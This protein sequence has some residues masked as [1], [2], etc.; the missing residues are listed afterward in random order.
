MIKDTD[1]PNLKAW[2][3]WI[4]QN[5]TLGAA[6]TLKLARG[7]SG[8]HLPARYPESQGDDYNNAYFDSLEAMNEQQRDDV[9]E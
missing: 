7:S 6:A 5:R 8:Y 1:T 2:S 9:R 4:D 3:S